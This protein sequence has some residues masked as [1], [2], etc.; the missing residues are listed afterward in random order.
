MESASEKR[1][2]LIIDAFNAFC[3]HY[4]ANP[5]MSENGDPAGGFVGFVKSLGSLC[6]QFDPAEV[7]VVWESGGNQ[8]RRSISGGS[9]KNNSRPA[10]LNRYYEDDIPNTKENHN[11]QIAL[12]VEA[13]KCLPIRQVYVKDTEADDVIGYLCHYKYPDSDIVIISSDRDL[14]QLISPRVKQWSLNQKK[15]IDEKEVIEKFGVT[16]QNFVS[17]R[18][19]IGDSSDSIDGIKGAG[20]KT[21]SKKFPELALNTH[22]S[23]SEIVDRAQTLATISNAKLLKSIIDGADEARKNWKL[24]HLDISKMNGDQIKRIEHQ[25]GTLIPAANKINL[26]RI[27][28]REGL[29]TVDIDSTFA[30]IKVALSYERK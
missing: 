18:A 16:P 20:F 19:F 25:I 12:T 14:Y 15:I 24:M 28:S 1:P 2:V 6:N 4:I 30:S 11:T 23:V 26:L 7:V 27:L 5:T 3:R 8:K 13:L 17:A 10:A 29:R 9:Y 22:I 21:L